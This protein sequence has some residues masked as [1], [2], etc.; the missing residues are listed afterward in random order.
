M[1]EKPANKVSVDVIL[2]LGVGVAI[3]A[4]AQFLVFTTLAMQN[5]AGGSGM[6]RNLPAEIRSKAPDGYAWSRNFLSDLGLQK[7]WSGKDNS[8]GARYFNGSIILLG[9][10]LILFFCVSVRA[11]ERGDV[12]ALAIAGAGG[13]SSLGLVGIGMTPYDVLFV[14]HHIMLA[15]WIMPLPI[16]A[17]AFAAQCFRAENR[18]GFLS[19]S[20]AALAA[21]GLIVAIIAYAVAPSLRDRV[22]MQKVLAGIAILWFTIVVGRV[23]LASITII[24]QRKRFRE[25]L[26]EKYIRQISKQYLRPHQHKD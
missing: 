26:A 4:I 24:S 12:I 21:V 22:L 5:Y 6:D 8:G 10:A 14:D 25:R 15:V 3:L 18:I 2:A 20:I 23:A 7:A 17:V 13:I 1:S 9:I 19:G 16:I 11:S